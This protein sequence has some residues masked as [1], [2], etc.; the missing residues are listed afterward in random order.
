MFFKQPVIMQSVVL[1]V[2]RL[3]PTY[4]FP[5]VEVEIWGGSAKNNLRLLSKVKPEATKNGAERALLKVEAKFKA[6]S[7]SYLKIVAKNL[8]VLP[9]WHPGKGEPAWLFVDEIFLN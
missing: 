9:N 3:V 7:I 8:K 2:M 4:I 1:N 5:P 6:Q